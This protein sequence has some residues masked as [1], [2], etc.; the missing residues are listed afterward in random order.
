MLFQKGSKYL[1]DVN[2]LI[3][4]A[5][6]SGLIDKELKKYAPNATE[7]LTRSDVQQSHFGKEKK[8]FKLQNIIGMVTILAVGI[9]VGLLTLISEIIIHRLG[10]KNGKENG[11]IVI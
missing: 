2:K 10:S 5:K 7:C 11:V 3:V 1:E 4:I 6:E 8:I 9:G